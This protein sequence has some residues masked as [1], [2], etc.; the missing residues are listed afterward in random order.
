MEWGK[1][2]YHCREI[3]EKGVHSRVFAYTVV[4]SW[5]DSTQ[6]GKTY[7]KGM[8]GTLDILWFWN[9]VNINMKWLMNASIH[10][11]MTWRHDDDKTTGHQ[12]HTATRLWVTRLQEPVYGNPRPRGVERMRTT[13]KH[14]RDAWRD[15]DN[16]PQHFSLLRGRRHCKINMWQRPPGVSWC[17]WNG[18]SLSGL[19][20]SVEAVSLSH[21]I[22]KQHEKVIHALVT[23]PNQDKPTNRF[24][25]EWVDRSCRSLYTTVKSPV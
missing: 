19:S 22:T 2:T 8:P 13:N 16:D 6:S 21:V 10:K 5:Y 24:V 18:L 4:L 23:S 9:I 3:D 12:Y 7:N 14:I 15:R 25:K 11:Y 20:L 1:K 17:N